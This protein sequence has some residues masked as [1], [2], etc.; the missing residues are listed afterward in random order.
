METQII[1]S[2]ERYEELM[3]Y[4]RFVHDKTSFNLSIPGFSGSDNIK[5]VAFETIPEDAIILQLKSEQ[6]KRIKLENEISTANF[7][8]R[9]GWRRLRKKY[10]I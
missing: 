7:H 5:I 1:I 10:Q 2:L 6:E 8:G 9:A 4:V 3:N